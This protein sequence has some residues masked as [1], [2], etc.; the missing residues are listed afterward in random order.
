MHRYGRNLQQILQAN[1]G[2]LSRRCIYQ[3]GIKLL[4]IFE[5]IHDSGIVY[6]DLKPDNIMMGHHQDFVNMDVN[7]ID[8][9]MATTWK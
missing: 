7:L 4:D 2:R 8:F 6:N 3:I 5:L 1:D 9:G